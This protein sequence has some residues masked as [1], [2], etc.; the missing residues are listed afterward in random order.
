[1]Q[2][3]KNCMNQK[4]WWRLAPRSEEGGAWRNYAS[5]APPGDSC[6]V[7]NNKNN[8]FRES[9][10]HTSLVSRMAVTN[11]PPGGSCCFRNPN[12]L[13]CTYEPQSIQL[14]TPYLYPYPYLVNAGISRQNGDGFGQYP[15]GRV[16]LPSLP[17]II[18]IAPGGN[19]RAA[20]WFLLFQE[21][22]HSSLH[23][24]TSIH[25]TPTVL[26]SFN[27]QLK[28]LYSMFRFTIHS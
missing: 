7:K 18:G 19:Q 15:W 2:F 6:F 24:Q 21:P 17:H 22:Q 26:V 16:Y 11:L 12:I 4:N 23:L 5:I 9:R 10:H 28:R 14:H 20:R 8:V 13:L 27:L 1:M 3:Y 25:S